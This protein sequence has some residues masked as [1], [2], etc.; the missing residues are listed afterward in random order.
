MTKCTVIVDIVH[1]IHLR[2]FAIV[3]GFSCNVEKFSVLVAILMSGFLRT[4][5]FPFLEDLLFT[6]SSMLLSGCFTS[7]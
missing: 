6:E 7:V 2:I 1:N 3:L 4:L 5:V